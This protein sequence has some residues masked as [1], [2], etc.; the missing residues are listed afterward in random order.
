VLVTPGDDAYTIFAQSMDRTGYARGTLAQQV[1]STAPVPAPDKPEP[2]TMGDMMGSMSGMGA[3]DH[4]WMA[5]D[6]G[7]HDMAGMSG[8]EGMND[9]NGM[10]HGGM[11]M[12][13]T[14]HDMSGMGDMGG[15]ATG[16]KFV[17]VRHAKTEYG[18]SV[19]MRVDTPRTSLDDPGVGLRNSGR[20]VL[21]Y[22]D[23]HSLPGI[24][25]TQDAE[26]EIELH[27]TG[28]MERY[29]WSLDGLEFGC[30]G[31][32]TARIADLLS[33]HVEAELTGALTYEG[34]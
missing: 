18:P 32:V 20:K 34:A 10:N 3:M 8:M 27:L 15:M 19:D 16:E 2:L 30:P 1:G 14:G 29:T 22:A 26:Q 33:E 31:P 13:Q 17:Q 5:M 24:M 23:L 6:P 9:M 11:S 7:T 12:D 28:N 4:G 21:T 25:H